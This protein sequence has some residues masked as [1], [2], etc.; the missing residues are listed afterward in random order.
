MSDQGRLSVVQ[1]QDGTL[2]IRLVGAWSLKAG[3]PSTADVQGEVVSTGI[4]KGVAFDTSELTSWDTS[5]LTF[6]VEI[7]ELCRQRGIPIF[8]SLTV[9]EHF[10]IRRILWSLKMAGSLMFS[11]YSWLFCRSG[12]L[13]SEIDPHAITSRGATRLTNVSFSCG[14]GNLKRIN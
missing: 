14:N 2:L 11:R 13:R 12:H 10:C 7:S 4:S 5:V 8:T 9:M 6:L 1:A 3:I